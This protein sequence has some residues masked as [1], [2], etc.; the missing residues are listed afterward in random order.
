MV[1]PP[2]YYPEYSGDSVSLKPECREVVKDYSVTGTYYLWI[3]LSDEVK[4]ENDNQFKYKY[5]LG[6][7]EENWK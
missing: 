5:N 6:K 7:F 1:G 3:N 4:T 2:Y